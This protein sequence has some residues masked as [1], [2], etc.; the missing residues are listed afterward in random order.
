MGWKN[1]ITLIANLKTEHRLMAEII[2]SDDAQYAINIVKM[3]CSKVGPGLPGTKQ[4]RQ[5]G[6]MI[7]KE[8]ENH[9]G[10]ENVITEEFM[11]AP[12]AFIST[13]PAVI[14]MLLAILLNIFGSR[15]GGIPLWLPAIGA[16]VFSIFPP[17]SFILEFLLSYEVFDSFFPKKLSTNVIGSLRKPGTKDVK[18]LLI[19]SGHHD[20]ALENTW[21]R[22]AP[23]WFYFF[24]TTFFFGMVVLVVVCLIQLI[25][26]VIESEAVV[27]RGTLGWV[28]LVYPIIPAMIYALFLT[29]G[30]KDGGI[31]PGAA[32]NL[33]ACAAVVTTCRFL[34]ANPSFIPDDTE[35]RF[36]SFGSEE[37]GC[38]GSRRYVN[39]HLEELKRL[40]ARLLNY[41]IIAYP[42]ISIP[43]S[44]VNGFVK[45]SPEMVNCVIGAAQR[46]GVPY[47]VGSA[48]L[49][50]GSDAAPFNRAGLK[51]LTLMLFKLPEQQYAF[52]H[53]DRDTPEV[54]TIEPF[55]NVLKLTIEWIKNG[56]K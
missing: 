10:S 49:G 34:V 3:I 52:Y 48:S 53:Q 2:T 15:I 24:S 46:S 44:D 4:E 37:A 13:L 51:G 14:C 32:D 22:Y 6:E 42:K 56:A 12:D 20:S 35:I 21:L 38:R 19:V 18:H 11:L 28:L 55:V 23:K 1:K 26:A 36:I 31:V 30:K 5:R 7:K 25:G 39:R 9:L 54:L 45:Y 47:K 50:A 8:L 27:Q 29:R 43:T 16:L 40:D 17:L 41:E 33:S